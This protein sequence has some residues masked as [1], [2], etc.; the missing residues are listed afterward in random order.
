MSPFK[1][2]QDPDGSCNRNPALAV[3]DN[4]SAAQLPRAA[5][6]EHAGDATEVANRRAEPDKELAATACAESAIGAPR[7]RMTMLN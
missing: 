5:S 4:L 7:I 1:S 3:A 6:A 2:D